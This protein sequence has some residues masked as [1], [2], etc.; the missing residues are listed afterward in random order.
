MGE[1]TVVLSVGSTATALLKRLVQAKVTA[2]AT[3]REAVVRNHQ[4]R[5]LADL[6]SADRL[7]HRGGANNRALHH[8]AKD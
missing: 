3:R 5:G 8:A 1:R 2:V 7:D 6:A 4:G